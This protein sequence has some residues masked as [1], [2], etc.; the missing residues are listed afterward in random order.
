MKD[1]YYVNLGSQEIS[2][3]KFGNNDEF[4]IYASDDE[5]R[6][7]RGKLNRM[8]DSDM[9]AFFRAHVPIMP[10]HNDK[11]NDDYDAGVTEAFQIIYD[12]GDNETKQHIE[13]IGILTDDRL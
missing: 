6:A 5:I 11:A 1:K 9:R 10:Y 8:R 12:L 2:R 7:L 3:T 4:I 13:D